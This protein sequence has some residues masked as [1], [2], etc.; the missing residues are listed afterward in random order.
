MGTAERIREARWQVGLDSSQL[1]STLGI[2]I[3][4][5]DDLEA[6]DNELANCLSVGQARQLAALLRTSVLDLLGER[7]PEAPISVSELRQLVQARTA[8]PSS[9][10][11]LE[12]R[13]GWE[14]RP[15]LDESVDF[16]S[17]VPIQALVDIGSALAIDWRRLL[18][19]CAPE[20][21]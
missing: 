16:D 10:E 14:L 8:G 5:Y 1:A 13:A 19:E 3:P 4:A 9:L 6:Y 17:L 11:A 2:T 7:C 12:D 20:G 18:V 21:Q 15:L